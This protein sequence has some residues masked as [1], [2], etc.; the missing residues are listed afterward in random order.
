LTA[1][2][3]PIPGLAAVVVVGAAV[4]GATVVVG[5]PVVVGAAVV[6]DADDLAALAAVV[7][8]DAGFD[9]CAD[10]D[11]GAAVSTDA[12][13]ESPHAISRNGKATT[14]ALSRIPQR[15]PFA[16]YESE[17][18]SMGSGDLLL[19]SRLNRGEKACASP[20][21]LATTSLAPRPARCV[22]AGGSNRICPHASVVIGLVVMGACGR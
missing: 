19:R 11:D 5:A 2:V 3:E 6:V 21:R 12:R 8:D 1:T 13:S 17:P 10:T 4:D 15:I 22:T 7:E 18:L 14:A 20:S 16:C 9:D